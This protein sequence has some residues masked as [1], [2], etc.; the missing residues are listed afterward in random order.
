M[1][2]FTEDPTICYHLFVTVKPE[3]SEN[4]D[5]SVLDPAH[6]RERKW[7]DLEI[8]IFDA[9]NKAAVK[10]DAKSTCKAVALII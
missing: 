1:E 8:F 10:L 3:L 2:T 9:L 4:D 7:Q 5:V 6:P